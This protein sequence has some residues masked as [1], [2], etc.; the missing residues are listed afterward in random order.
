LTALPLGGVVSDSKI[1]I[2]VGSISFSGEGS[3]DWLSK[4]LDKVLAKIP[5]LVAVAPPET[6]VNGSTSGGTP[7]ATGGA[8]R[9]RA[10]GTLATFLKTKNVND[11][12]N[13]KFLA[14]AVWLHD[15]EH[16]DRLRTKEVT[17]ALSTHK[18][19]SLTNASNCLAENA[20]RGYCV[21]EGKLFYVADEGRDSLA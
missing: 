1:E 7:Q 20:K 15:A 10:S 13:R 18:Q 19:G 5:E 6:P 2:K 4:Q 8:Q 14:T 12:Q 16:K 17:Q 9:G 21:R 3:G 11:S